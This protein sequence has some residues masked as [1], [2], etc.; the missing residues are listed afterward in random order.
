MAFVVSLTCLV[1]PE[2]EEVSVL[3]LFCNS[4]LIC[5][6]VRICSAMAIE[7][8][9]LCFWN[10]FNSFV[11]KLSTNACFRILG[12]FP[13]DCPCRPLSAPPSFPSFSRL[14]R[15][16]LQYS[17]M[18]VTRELSVL[19]NADVG[20][21]TSMLIIKAR[22]VVSKAVPRPPNTLFIEEV[23][24]ETSEAFSRVADSPLTAVLTPMTVP[25]K[26]NI[27]IAQ[28]KTLIIA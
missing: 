22:S 13:S 6:A 20:I 28:I 5:V 1:R 25:I 27:G 8:S 9:A 23:T 16:S 11:P 7:F 12:V 26:P 14:S 18:R 24:A 2:T 4:R 3:K 19:C 15:F 17:S 10:C 21:L